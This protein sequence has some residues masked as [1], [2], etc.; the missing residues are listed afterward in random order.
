MGVGY[1]WASIHPSRYDNWEFKLPLIFLGYKRGK[2]TL[3]GKYI[4]IIAKDYGK[5]SGSIPG[6]GKGNGYNLA[7]GYKINKYINFILSLGGGS[8]LAKEYYPN[9]TSEYNVNMCFNGIGISLNY[10]FNLKGGGK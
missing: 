9:Q 3:K 4:F 10:V 1:G 8:Y 7:L 2:I 5:V 6:E